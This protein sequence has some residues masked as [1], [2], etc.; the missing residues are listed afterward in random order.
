MGLTNI[1]PSDYTCT[2]K[3]GN[4]L[5]DYGI[6][7]SFWEPARVIEAVYQPN[8]FPFLFAMDLGDSLNVSG[9]YGE[10]GNAV[11][12]GDKAFYNAHYYAFP[13]LSVMDILVGADY[14]TDWLNDIDLMY[15]TE[16]DPLWND[17]ELT[18]FLN[19]EAIVFGNPVAQAL[20][21]VDCAAASAGFPLNSLFWCAGCWGSL[22]PYTGNTGTTGSPVRTSSLITAKMLARLTRLPVPPAI[23]FDTSSAGAKCGGQI[24][25]LI[26]KSQY[27]LSTLFP[28][29]EESSHS[30]G[31]ST[32]SWG[33]HRNI[34][35]TGEFQIYLIWRKRNCCLKIL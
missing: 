11:E 13:L 33:D 19:P 23:E 32:L 1:Y 34:P 14:C 15:F 35:A 4:G 31:S 9:A 22:Y 29:P 16:V 5:N 17:D 7:V 21:S 20:C 10:R 8:C 3:N 2:C 24:R 26:K 12:T 6:Y 25:P 28:I 18:G 30:L 27:K